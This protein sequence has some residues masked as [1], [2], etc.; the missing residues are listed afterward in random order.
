MNKH[1]IGLDAGHG[2]AYT[3]TYSV[4]TAKTGLYEKDLTLEL[5]KLVR[6]RLVAHGFGVV[7]TRET[8]VR[9]G[10][11]SQRAAQLA[12]A[13][14]AYAVSIHFNG[15]ANEAAHGAEVF[16]PYGALDGKIEAGY[17]RY[18]SP[19]FA[20]RA[21]FARSNN[22]QN[23]NE[24]FDKK[25]NTATGVYGATTKLKA[26]YFGFVRTGWAAGMLSDLLEVCFLTNRGDYTAYMASKAKVADAIAR[27]IV[28]GF[29]EEWEP[30]PEKKPEPAPAPKQLY[31]VGT[32]WKDGKCVNQSGAFYNLQYAVNAC[33]F[34]E[35][36]FTKAGTIVYENVYRKK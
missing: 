18:L 33:K 16:V 21:P 4:E 1:L 28:E 32:G 17:Q 30:K 7:M 15:A 20:I 35:K 27:A 26:D 11:V 36:V 8:D 13:G 25:L 2:G 6:D 29:G 10:D 22:A 34:G 23:R 19:L 12:R 31:R 14:C 5:A 3:G 9:P 24:T